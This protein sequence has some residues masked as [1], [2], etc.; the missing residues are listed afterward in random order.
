MTWYHLKQEEEEQ[1]RMQKDVTEWGGASTEVWTQFF[2]ILL[3]DD[4]P[5]FYFDDLAQ[6]A[7]VLPMQ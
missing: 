5:Q 6:V 3:G 2:L 7:F 4:L 1:C